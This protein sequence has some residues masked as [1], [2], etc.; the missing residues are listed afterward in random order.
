MPLNL[1]VFQPLKLIVMKTKFLLSVLL[2]FYFCLLPSQVPQGFNYQAI[3]R[4]GTGAVLPNQGLTVRISIQPA[5]ASGNE[6]WIETHSIITDKFGVMVL[7][8]GNGSKTGGSAG[9]FSDIPWGSQTLY[10]KTEIE[11]PPSIPDFTVMGTTQLWSVPYSLVAGNL[12][13][14]LSQLEVDGTTTTKDP[15]LFAVRNAAGD[16]VF[17]VYNEAVRVY[18]DNGSKGAKGGFAIGGFGTGKSV[19]QKYFYVKSDTVRVYIDDTD[20]GAKGGFAIGGFGT[21][22]G[23]YDSYLKVQTDT[24]AAGKVNYLNLTPLNVFIGEQAGLKTVPSGGLN[25]IYNSFIGYQAGLNNVSGYQNC[26]MG[27]Q[28]GSGNISGFTNVFIGNRAG[29]SNIGGYDNVFLGDAS[30][31]SNQS[32]TGNTFIGYGSGLNNI[33]GGTNT[34]I[35]SDAGANNDADF[36]TFL[37]YSSG[38]YNTS[39]VENIFLGYYAG[40]YN[41]IGVGNTMIG[42]QGRGGA[43]ISISKQ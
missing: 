5:L 34:F 23:K 24:V 32:G 35:G 16:T 12:K 8:I 18:V 10:L 43:G 33:S 2:S 42:S 15:A 7:V 27:Y 6:F 4:D 20:K 19:S 9:V 36:N 1:S 38:Y 21:S 3:A 37:G 22:K 13:G 26:F 30:G 40:Y 17:A 28:A 25:G 41:K 14:S 31:Y 11:N 39:G 29:Y